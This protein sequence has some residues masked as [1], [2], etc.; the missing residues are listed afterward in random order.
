MVH[1]KHSK[2][3][4][5][6]VIAAYLLSWAWPCNQL[7]IIQP[8]TENALVT[9]GP[10][11]HCTRNTLGKN[12]AHPWFSYFCV[13]FIKEMCL[14]LLVYDENNWKGSGMRSVFV[15][16]VTISLNKATLINANA[17]CMFSPYNISI[18]RPSK[19]SSLLH[20]SPKA[21]LNCLLQHQRKSLWGLEK[22]HFT[23]KALC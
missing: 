22:S 4:S 5:H 16:I 15:S 13:F 11:V 8:E 18:L 14:C 9:V 23:Q 12:G 21:C 2:Y 1:N 17:N 19:D 6:D 20:F 7:E 3:P 10:K